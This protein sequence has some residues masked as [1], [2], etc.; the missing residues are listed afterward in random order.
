M[1]ENMKLLVD[2]CRKVDGLYQMQGWRGTSEDRSFLARL[3][4]CTLKPD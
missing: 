4:A 1:D 3:L 2:N